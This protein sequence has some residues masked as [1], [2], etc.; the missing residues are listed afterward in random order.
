MGGIGNQ[1]PPRH[2]KSAYVKGQQKQEWQRN[3][4]I[5]I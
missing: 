2:E 1:P 5:K 4:T 3:A